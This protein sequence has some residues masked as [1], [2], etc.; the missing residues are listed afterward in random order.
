VITPLPARVEPLISPTP[1]AARVA[2]DGWPEYRNTHTPNRE[3]SFLYPPSLQVAIDSP[4][5]TIFRLT[6]STGEADTDE[7]LGLRYSTNVDHRAP[8]SPTPALAPLSLKEWAAQLPVYS[9][10][11]ANTLLGQEELLLSDRPAII[12][13]V[14]SS[15]TRSEYLQ[16]LIPDI[17]AT[18]NDDPQPNLRGFVIDNYNP[19]IV[20]RNQF[21]TLLATFRSH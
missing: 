4:Q 11:P 13:T 21:I 2:T 8:W 15:T 14:R 16:V 10:S 20:D 12:N 5:Y 1:L 6:D 7:I 19:E 17:Y 9:S 3:I 18:L